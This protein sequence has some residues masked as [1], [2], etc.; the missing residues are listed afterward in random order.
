[1]NGSGNDVN[2][3]NVRRVAGFHNGDVGGAFANGKGHDILIY[4]IYGEVA[5]YSK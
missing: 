3:N 5:I 2:V 4:A 1:M